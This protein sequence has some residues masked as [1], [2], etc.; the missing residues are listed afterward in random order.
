MRAGS[1]SAAALH[2]VPVSGSDE[3]SPEHCPR[4]EYTGFVAQQAI[5]PQYHL[6]KL[7]YRNFLERWPSLPAWFAAPLAERVGRIR[8]DDSR[9]PS[10]PT[11]YL[12]RSYLVFLGLRGYARFDYAWLLGSEQLILHRPGA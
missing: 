4:L 12:A 9:H 6:R 1:V 11:S 5:N 8:G 2:A 10:F 3:L 7:R